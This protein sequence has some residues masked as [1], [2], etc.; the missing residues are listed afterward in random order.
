MLSSGSVLDNNGWSYGNGNQLKFHNWHGGNNQ[1]WYIVDCGNGYVKFINKHSGLVIDISNNG[2]SNG[3]PIQQWTDTGASA[4]RFKLLPNNLP[5]SS[6]NIPNGIYQIQGKTSGKLIHSKNASDGA[7]AHLWSSTTNPDNINNQRYN[8]QRQSDGTYKII[9]LSSNK[10]L[11]N[12]NLSYENG[13][14]LRFYNWNGA[15]NQKWYVVDC[16]NG[17]VKFINKHSGLAIDISNNGTENGTA[18]QQ[19]KDSAVGASAQRFKLL[20]S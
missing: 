15:N 17:Y 1:R 14:Q 12:P 9:V 4:Q 20:D 16:G 3:T 13:T 10:V 19:W 18:I 6:M 2:T 11:T 8:F 5:T 7:V